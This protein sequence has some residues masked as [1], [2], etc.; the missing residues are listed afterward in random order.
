MESRPIVD[1]PEDEHPAG[2]ACFEGIRSVASEDP[3]KAVV[4]AADGEVECFGFRG[5][6]ELVGLWD[7]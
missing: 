2:F 7:L 5:H 3:M 6:G 1:R 4:F